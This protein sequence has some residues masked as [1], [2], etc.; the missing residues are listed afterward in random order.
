MC[1]AGKSTG[2]ASGGLA[3]GSGMMCDLGLPWPFLS[4][5]CAEL[6][7]R[8]WSHRS[9]CCGSDCGSGDCRM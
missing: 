9:T 8:V 1:W 4:N 5:E 6:S 3:L 7:G 2:W